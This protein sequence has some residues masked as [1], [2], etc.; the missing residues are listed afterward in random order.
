MGYQIIAISPDRPEK[1][2]KS[3]EAKQYRYLF[4]SDSN[5]AASSAFGIAFRLSDDLNKK[6]RGYGINIEAASGRKDHILPVPAVF[7]V[8]TDGIIKFEYANPDY[9]VRLDIEVLMSAAK[10][11]VKSN[12]K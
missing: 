11:A 1:I 4:L 12:T 6:Y 2:Q 10:A 5:N 8:G 7:L 9:R 3:L